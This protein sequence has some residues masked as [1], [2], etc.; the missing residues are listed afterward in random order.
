MSERIR[1]GRLGSYQRGR[2][3]SD[4]DNVT[5]ESWTGSADDGLRDGVDASRRV[6]HQHDPQS[7]WASLTLSR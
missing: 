7:V 2:A 1:K 6:D 3:R 4:A 5:R